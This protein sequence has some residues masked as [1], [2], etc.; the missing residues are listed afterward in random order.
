MNSV[1]THVCTKTELLQ[2]ASQK[3]KVQTQFIISY[4]T[5]NYILF[6]AFT[7]FRRVKNIM[8]GTE[9]EDSVPK[10]HIPNRECRPKILKSELIFYNRFLFGKYYTES[11]LNSKVLYS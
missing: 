3:K 1:Y 6:T 4:I 5:Y 7:T 2:S 10:K 8:T 9:I 11:K